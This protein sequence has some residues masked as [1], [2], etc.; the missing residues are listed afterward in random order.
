M[1][2]HFNPL[3]KINLKTAFPLSYD[4]IK[5]CHCYM[6]WCMY[7]VKQSQISY[8]IS[9]SNIKRFP[10][11][12][13]VVVAKFS[14]FQNKCCCSHPATTT[15]MVVFPSADEHRSFYRHAHWKI[16]VERHTI[17]YYTQNLPLL[18]QKKKIYKK[19]QKWV[20]ISQTLIQKCQCK[21]QLNS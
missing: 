19:K 10:C 14:V 5:L 4:G 12:P 1:Y 11:L 8:Q 20:Y 2:Y 13:T 9:V 15:R 17:I 3:Q 18:E 21:Y 16:C 7:L 6:C